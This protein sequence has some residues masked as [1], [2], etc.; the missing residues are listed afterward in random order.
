MDLAAPIQCSIIF[1]RMF[2]YTKTS[3]GEYLCSYLFTRL[4]DSGFW[5]RFQSKHLLP[6]G[7]PAEFRTFFQQGLALNLVRR[8]ILAGEQARHYLDPS[9]PGFLSYLDPFIDKWGLRNIDG[10]GQLVRLV[11]GSVVASNHA[12]SES[13]RQHLLQWARSEHRHCY[14]CG[15][16]LNFSVRPGVPQYNDI[17]LDHLWPQAYGGDSV[18][19][20]ILPAC[21]SCNHE[22]KQDYPSWA[23]CNVHTLHRPA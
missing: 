7:R 14:M 2:D 16:I 5:N 17:T 9:E 20:N 23:G 19:D 6:T 4:V 21:R 3:D 22:K 18:E 1:Q 10:R 11:R 15:S 12:I 13:L 8:L